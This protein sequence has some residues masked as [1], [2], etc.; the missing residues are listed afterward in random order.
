MHG[1]DAYPLSALRRLKAAGELATLDGYPSGTPT[2]PPQ[3]A[4]ASGMRLTLLASRLIEH[5]G[6]GERRFMIADVGVMFADVLPPV[7]IL[8]PPG[9]K[10]QIVGMTWEDTMK[11]AG[12]DT[13]QGDQWA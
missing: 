3:R 4:I 2:P 9:Y 7:S 11:P 8:T 13:D 12:D 10:I 6:R 5:I 1:D